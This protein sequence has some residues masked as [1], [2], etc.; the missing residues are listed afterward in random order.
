MPALVFVC[1]I[2]LSFRSQVSSARKDG[3]KDPVI[4]RHII[5]PS[6]SMWSHESLAQ[7]RSQFISRG[8]LRHLLREV[9][10][11]HAI[12]GSGL[13]AKLWLHYSQGTGAL[14][15]MQV[16]KPDDD[17]NVGLH[18]EAVNEQDET[19]PCESWRVLVIASKA[20][21]PFEPL[22][23]AAPRNE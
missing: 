21:M 22:V 19:G 6:L 9:S 1:R 17:G 13:T 14:N 10:L 16:P 11:S 8:F 18:W 15:Q 2:K 12:P 23:R 20:I 7:S 3:R 4:I 5:W